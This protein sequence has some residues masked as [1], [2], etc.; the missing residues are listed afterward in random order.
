M[1]YVCAVDGDSG[2]R[3]TVTQ[4]AG[5]QGKHSVFLNTFGPVRVSEKNGVAVVFY[6]VVYQLLCRFGTGNL[7]SVCDIYASLAYMRHDH[8]SF[9]KREIAVAL[10]AIKALFGECLLDRTSLSYAVTAEYNCVAICVGN[11]R[12]Q[13]FICSVSIRNDQYISMLHR[14]TPFLHN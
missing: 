8:R 9:G 12:I 2:I 10:Y 5:V 6:R 1:L 4:T 14:S 13:R 3:S 11:D 7:T